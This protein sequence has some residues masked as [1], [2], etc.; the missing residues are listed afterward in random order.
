MS[1]ESAT[2]IGLIPGALAPKVKV[3]GNAALAGA[4][5]LL[6]NQGAIRDVREIARR[7]R[8]VNLGGNPSF[9]EHYMDQMFFPE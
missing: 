7:A 4:A 3:L 1:V 2:R 8:H 5:Q 9:N 6:L